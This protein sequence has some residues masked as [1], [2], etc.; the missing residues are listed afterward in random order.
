MDQARLAARDPVAPATRS[1]AA[2]DKVASKCLDDGSPAHSFRTLL[3][4]LSTL[5]RNTC[6]R[7][8]AD[9]QECIFEI[10]TTPNAKQQ[11]ALR[12]IDAIRL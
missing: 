11:E 4:E 3:N 9:S 12:L 5:V 10:D 8:H 2:L 6:R 1:E 7:K